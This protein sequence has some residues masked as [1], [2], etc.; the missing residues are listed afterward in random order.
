MINEWLSTE[1]IH[2]NYEAQM[3]TMYEYIMI[4]IK[5]LITLSFFA[6]GEKNPFASAI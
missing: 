4:I 5:T 1:N 6:L 2:R 3:L